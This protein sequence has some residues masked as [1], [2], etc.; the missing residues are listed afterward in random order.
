MHEGFLIH[1]LFAEYCNVYIEVD[2]AQSCRVIILWKLVYLSLLFDDVMY[3]ISTSSSF[4]IYHLPSTW[5][6]MIRIS[7]A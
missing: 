1:I 3:S 7:S 5:K 2:H 6:A 4:N